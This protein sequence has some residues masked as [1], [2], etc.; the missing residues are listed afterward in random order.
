MLHCSP[1]RRARTPGSCVNHPCG[2][3]ATR[4]G[5]IRSVSAVAKTDC[6][7][8]PINEKQ[9]LFMVQETRFFGIRVAKQWH[10]TLLLAQAKLFTVQQGSFQKDRSE[11]ECFALSSSNLRHVILASVLRFAARNGSHGYS[12]P[13]NKAEN[14]G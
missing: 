2:P 7:L 3:V 4:D 14:I 10:G 6:V 5:G 9:F 11:R 8:V 12:H 1:E 13:I